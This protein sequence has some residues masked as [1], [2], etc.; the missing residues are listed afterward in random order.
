[1][2]SK[3]LV[4]SIV[5]AFLAIGAEAQGQR[6]TLIKKHPN[7]GEGWAAR[8]GLTGANKPDCWYCRL[9][10]DVKVSNLQRTDHTANLKLEISEE[11]ADGYFGLYRL[12]LGADDYQ[13]WAVTYDKNGNVLK[14][15]DLCEKTKRYDLELQDIRYEAGKF[16]FNMACPTYSSGYNGKCSALYCMDAESGEVEWVTDFLVSNDVLIVYKNYIVCGYGFTDEKDYVY[17]IDKKNGNMLSKV[18]VASSPQYIEEKDG[19]IYVMDYRESMYVF[20]I[21]EEK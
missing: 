4:I 6:L 7:V 20:K 1:M 16:Y 10:E 13:F 19:K 11:T 3:L 8:F 14:E 12:P 2:K 17:L 15:W 5:I 9:R 21:T 18:L